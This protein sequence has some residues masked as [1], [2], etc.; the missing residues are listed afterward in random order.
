VAPTRNTWRAGRFWWEPAHGA[1]RPADPYPLQ[2]LVFDL[3]ALTDIECDGH[4]VVFNAAFA[5]HGLDIAWTPAR[6]RR[7][8]ALHDERRRVAA[9]LR[10]RGVCTECDVLLNLLADEIVDT[11]QMMFEEM[12]LAADLTPRPGLA[13]LVVE[14][15]AEGISVAVVADGQ[16]RWVEPLVRELVGEGL[17][18]TLVTADDL[19]EP[20]RPADGHRLALADLWVPAERVLAFTGSAHGLRTATAAGL[21]T[22]VVTGAG[23]PELAGAAATRPDYAAPAPLRVEDCR[24]LAANWWTG[25]KPLIAA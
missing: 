16:R 3:D 18:T 2:A 11:K 25:H 1:A 14:A 13:D 17:V 5:A 10:A 23:R 24:E 15:F 12:I 20:M 21:A 4:R 22:V 8:L 9:E 6:Y 19:A 7:L